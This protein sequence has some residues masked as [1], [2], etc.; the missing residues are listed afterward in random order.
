M[1]GYLDGKW[2]TFMIEA[3]VDQFGEGRIVKVHNETLDQLAALRQ[4]IE[5]LEGRVE[6]LTDRLS[7]TTEDYIRHRNALEAAER[8][9]DEARV[10][11][12]RLRAPVHDPATCTVCQGKRDA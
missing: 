4:R 12:A 8:E 7:S 3:E 1:R 5:E 2:S 11:L 9:R 6:S 10:K